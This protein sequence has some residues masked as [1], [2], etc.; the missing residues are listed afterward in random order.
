MVANIVSFLHTEYERLLSL[1]HLEIC[2]QLRLS[3][4]KQSEKW[5]TLVLYSVCKQTHRQ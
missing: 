3:Q 5:G 4:G 2:D 1:V